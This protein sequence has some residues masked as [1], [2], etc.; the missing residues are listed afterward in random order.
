ML[1]DYTLDMKYG[2]EIATVESFLP[3][4]GRQK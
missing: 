2:G 4:A 3:S 1:K